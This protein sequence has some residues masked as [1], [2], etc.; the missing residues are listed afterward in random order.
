ME[1]KFY[2][3]AGL[4]L[5]LRSDFVTVETDLSRPFLTGPQENALN[6]IL[7]QTDDV[8]Q[9][10]GEVCLREELMTVYRDGDIVYRSFVTQKPNQ[11]QYMLSKTAPGEDI[12]LWVLRSELSWCAQ[13]GYI[14]LALGLNHLLLHSG[15]LVLHS[16]V[17][18]TKQGAIVFTAVSGTGKST[19]AGLWEKYMGAEVVNGDRCAVGFLDGSPCVFGVPMAGTSGISKNKTLSLRAMVS[20]GQAPENR[21]V[22]LKGAQAL[23]KVGFCSV[24]D[25]WDTGDHQKAMDMLSRIMETVPVF[26]LDCLPDESAVMTLKNTLEEIE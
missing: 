12:Q 22:R 3:I 13:M 11:K 8:P 21:I 10:R 14:W 9:P 7:M 16:S 4:R 17:V 2:E 23:L 19:Q 25:R 5:C 18:E 24:I 20:L 1:V 6:C 26:S 15:R